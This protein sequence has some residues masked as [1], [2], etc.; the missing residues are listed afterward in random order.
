MDTTLRALLVLLQHNNYTVCRTQRRLVHGDNTI[1]VNISSNITCQE[2]YENGILDFCSC[3]LDSIAVTANISLGSMIRST[4]SSKF[5]CFLPVSTSASADSIAWVCAVQQCHNHM[6]IRSLH[7]VH[8]I[9]N[10]PTFPECIG[11]F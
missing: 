1:C 10:F 3:N 9:N 2:Y 8:C 6:I 5:Q 4:R 11:S 7:T